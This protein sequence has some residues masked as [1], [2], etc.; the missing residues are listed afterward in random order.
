[1]RKL[2]AFVLILSILSIFVCSCS[3]N[4]SYDIDTTQLSSTM[5]FSLVTNMTNKP[6]E[7]IG[8]SVKMRG[9]FGVYEDP[10]TQKRYYACLFNDT[11]ACC[12]V[13]IE[14]ETSENLDYPN[15]FPKVGEDI[16]VAGVFDTY[17]EGKNMYCYLKSA[18]VFN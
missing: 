5:V 7:Y 1:M 16:T 17:F 13:S 6:D 11:T 10:T 9:Q 4:E 2:I 14:F 12:L 8:K 15:D 18:K 3:K